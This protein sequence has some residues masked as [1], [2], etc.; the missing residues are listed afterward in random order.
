MG[1]V[2]LVMGWQ[3]GGSKGEAIELIELRATMELI[4][5]GAG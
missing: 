3:L 4:E 5:L 1:L 2:E